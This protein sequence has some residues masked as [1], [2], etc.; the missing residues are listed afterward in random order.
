MLQYFLNPRG[1]SLPKNLVKQC[2]MDLGSLQPF[3]QWHILSADVESCPTLR[4]LSCS[5]PGRNAYPRGPFVSDIIAATHQYQK[6]KKIQSAISIHI[7]VLTA[8]RRCNKVATTQHGVCDM[9]NRKP[10]N[11][12]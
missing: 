1:C 11:S 4:A 12:N 2:L 8:A 10:G 3:K 5:L 6:F 7:N 9:S